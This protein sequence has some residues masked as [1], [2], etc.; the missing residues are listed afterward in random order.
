MYRTTLCAVLLCLTMHA[1]VAA[2]EVDTVAAIAEQQRALQ[3]E[4]E[5]GRATDLTARQRNLIR[6][7]QA[8][9]FAL[10]E[11]KTRLDQLTIDEQVRLD[12]ALE[13]INAELVNTTAARANE[14][15]CRRERRTGSRFDVT[16]CATANERDEIRGR[17]RA[18]LEKRQICMG[19]GCGS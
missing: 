14:D 19:P 5:S 16:Q 8:E 7:A 17:S 4:I 1:P 10:I 2:E 6:K 18:V 15:Q 11:G 12:N 9:V 3:A 13:R